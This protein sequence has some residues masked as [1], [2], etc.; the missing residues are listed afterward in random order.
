[1][2][3]AMKICGTCGTTN[4]TNAKTRSKCGTALRSSMTQLGVN[5]SGKSGH[6]KR[7]SQK[8]KPKIKQ[9]KPPIPQKKTQEKQFGGLE[10]DN[11]QNDA[12]NT[13]FPSEEQYFKPI[14][15][16]NTTPST[17]FFSRPKENG[18]PLKPIP[19]TKNISSIIFQ[20][21]FSLILLIIPFLTKILPKIDPANII[22]N[23]NITISK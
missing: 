18:F 13:N 17:G 19:P 15:M 11:F 9:Q 8:K 12:K 23:D 14:P 10:E 20:N 5:V 4:S 7:K 16:G 22:K 3:K 2:T 1:M 21:N 6:S